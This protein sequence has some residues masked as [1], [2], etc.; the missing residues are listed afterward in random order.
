MKIKFTI[1]LIFIGWSAFGQNRTVTTDNLRAR[2][3]IRLQDHT[4]TDIESDTALVSDAHTHLPTSHAVR[5]FVFNHMRPG[6]TDAYLSNDTLFLVT[7]DTTFTI[8]M[9]DYAQDGIIDF[10]KDNDTL[11]L[12]T[13]SQTYE[14]PIPAIGGN[15]DENY[16]PL[17]NAQGSL[18]NSIIYQQPSASGAIGIGTTSTSGTR[19]VVQ[20]TGAGSN[21]IISATRSNGTLAWRVMEDGRIEFGVNAT[22]PSIF[23]SLNTNSQIASVVGNQ[24]SYRSTS[25]AQGNL[26]CHYF[27][28]ASPITAQGGDSTR[29]TL[30]DWT[31]S[32][33]GGT[34]RN[35]GLYLKPIINQTGGASGITGGITVDPVL[36]SAADWR[37]FTSRAASGIAFYDEG[38]AHSRLKGTLQIESSIDTAE[39]KF[40]LVSNDEGMLRHVRVGSGIMV[41]QDSIWADVS[42]IEPQNAWAHVTLNEPYLDTIAAANSKIIRYDLTQWM[43]DFIRSN[44]ELQYDGLDTF[45]AKIDVHVSIKADQQTSCQLVIYASYGEVGSSQITFEPGSNIVHV[46]TTVVHGIPIVDGIGGNS[47]SAYIKNTD[48][49]VRYF[50]IER[51]IMTI[52][53]VSEWHPVGGL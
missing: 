41:N 35:D 33:S 49:N 24:M 18:I 29:F 5:E 1:W 19:L 39:G 21:P 11:F 46:S 15:G 4:I 10:Y 13:S 17:F 6:L 20:G 47:F 12:I 51:A 2:E 25:I 8:D 42:A 44:H 45:I 3:S 53:K 52:H 14:V 32:P 27:Y 23:P 30:Y 48:S 28:N 9:V 36:Q 43:N 31:F 40:V 7:N 34:N 38:G 26:T 37:S 16:V 22:K 50:T